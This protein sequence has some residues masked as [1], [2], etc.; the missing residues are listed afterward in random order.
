[1]EDLRREQREGVLCLNMLPT[2]PLCRTQNLPDCLNCDVRKG[3]AFLAW[4]RAK[5]EAESA[6]CSQEEQKQELRN[7]NMLATTQPET[8]LAPHTTVY[9][10]NTTPDA[11]QRAGCVYN[12]R[13]HNRHRTGTN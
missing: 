10:P 12:H 13:C 2:I 5:T 11:L 8:P 9:G 4:H 1:M 7:K 3:C 6:A